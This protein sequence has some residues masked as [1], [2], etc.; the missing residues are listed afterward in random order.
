[1]TFTSVQVWSLSSAWAGRKHRCTPGGIKTNCGGMCCWG[2]T[3]W[4]PRSFYEDNEGKED[5]VV[6][7]GIGKINNLYACGYLGEHGCTLSPT[8]RPIKCLLFPFV[9]NSNNKIVCNNWI[10]TKKGVC[11]GNHNNG[12]IAIDSVRANLIELFGEPLVNLARVNVVI[13]IDSYFD[14]PDHVIKSY[15]IE[16]QQEIN[17]KKPMPRSRHP[18]N[19]KK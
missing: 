10:T 3:Y 16:H 11:K 7:N 9:L 1:M 8:D 2:K 13:G 15:E 12:P 17:N 6:K 19:V 5:L 14:V 4:P 18:H